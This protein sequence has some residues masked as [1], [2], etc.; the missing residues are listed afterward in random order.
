MRPEE[1]LQYCLVNL[2]D[3]VLAESWGELVVFYNPVRVR[4]RGVYVL[5][6]K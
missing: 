5:T 2:A 4:K 6:V 1:I 3:T